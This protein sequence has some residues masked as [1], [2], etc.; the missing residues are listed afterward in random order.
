MNQSSRP[1]RYSSLVRTKEVAAPRGQHNQRCNA[2]FGQFSVITEQ[3]RKPACRSRVLQHGPH[4][5]NICSFYNRKQRGAKQ[6]LLQEFLFR[7]NSVRGLPSVLSPLFACQGKTI[8]APNSEPSFCDR[9]SLAPLLTSGP[10]RGEPRTSPADRKSLDA[11]TPR[12]KVRPL[13]IARSTRALPRP[14]RRRPSQRSAQVRTDS[15]SSEPTPHNS[16]PA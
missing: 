6:Q 1:R 15:L 14:F 13:S 7:K 12:P 8:S 9:E 2:R 10:R 3:A 11:K 4:R 5:L 16:Y